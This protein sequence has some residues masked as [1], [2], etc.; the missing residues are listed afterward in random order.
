MPAGSSRG[1]TLRAAIAGRLP[2]PGEHA[3]QG[4]EQAAGSLVGHDAFY[5]ADTAVVYPPT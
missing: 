2:P 4:E 1:I 3:G 5:L